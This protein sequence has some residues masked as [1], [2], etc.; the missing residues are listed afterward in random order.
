MLSSVEMP[1]IGSV[2]GAV[3]MIVIGS[4]ILL[5][6][7]AKAFGNVNFEANVGLK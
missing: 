1:G 2:A 6:L 3:W 4:L 5:I 7:L